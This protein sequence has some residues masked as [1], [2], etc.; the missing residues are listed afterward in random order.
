MIIVEAFS[1]LCVY[2]NAQ[3]K[4]L[5]ATVLY[6]KLLTLCRQLSY[7]IKH[8]YLTLNMFNFSFMWNILCV[9][10][11]SNACNIN[12]KF[13][14][15]FWKH[16]LR[17]TFYFKWFA[18]PCNLTS[19]KFNPRECV[20]KSGRSGTICKWGDVGFCI[21]CNCNHKKTCFHSHSRLLYILHSC[22]WRFSRDSRECRVC[23]TLHCGSTSTLDSATS[24]SSNFRNPATI[25]Q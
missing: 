11:Q 3:H 21:G 14:H 15:F 23:F 12:S 8:V 10:N 13:K 19:V 18:T 4:N 17:M 20:S 7:A 9:K 16:E 22:P 1:L 5:V 25:L 2:E 24:A 6:E